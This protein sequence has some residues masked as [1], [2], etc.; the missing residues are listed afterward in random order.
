MKLYRALPDIM[1]GPKVWQIFKIWTVRKPNVFLPGRRT[2]KTLLKEGKKIKK[3]S[4]T[5]LSNFLNF[6]FT[7]GLRVFDTKFV[8]KGLIL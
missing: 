2:V 5:F 4:K 1:S 7:F 3:I 6:F 8:S